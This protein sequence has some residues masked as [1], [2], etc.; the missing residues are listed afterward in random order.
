M[1]GGRT[2]GRND[3]KRHKLRIKKK[4]KKTQNE[5]E[6]WSAA[7]ICQ[8]FFTLSHWSVSSSGLHFHKVGAEGEGMT[9][10]IPQRQTSN[11]YNSRPQDPSVWHF[12]TCVCLCVCHILSSVFY[13]PA[14]RLTQRSVEM[15]PA[16]LPGFCS[17]W[18]I[19][20]SHTL[21]LAGWLAG[22]AYLS[23]V[24]VWV[25]KETECVSS[26]LA[27]RFPDTSAFRRQA[28]GK[29]RCAVHR[30]A[31]SPRV[32]C[33]R[34]RSHPWRR[35]SGKENKANSDGSS[36]TDLSK[37]QQTRRYFWQDA[38]QLIPRTR[39]GPVGIG[40]YQIT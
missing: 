11:S 27:G 24:A 38:R 7:D 21:K 39:G 2:L 8:A 17:L 40:E 18:D 26:P 33:R 15:N 23:N 31:E 20:A 19:K 22:C 35:R 30:P 3:E 6:G 34:T 29:Y 14:S 25:Q 10:L 32:S 9:L 36:L 37:W 16:P 5:K 12:F 1:R 4:K 28:A 13:L